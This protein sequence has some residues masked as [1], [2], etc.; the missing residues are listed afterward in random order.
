MSTE[1]IKVLLV[2]AHEKPVTIEIP[3]NLKGFQQ[4]VGGYIE[5]YD[6]EDGTSL[7]CDDEANLKYKDGNRYFDDGG[8]IAGD[9]IVVG[10]TED[11]NCRSL[12]D[13]EVSK[14]MD[15]YADAPDISPAE[16]AAD[17]GFTSFTF[18]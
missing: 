12:T 10:T 16:T 7:I 2:Q 9:F 18:S 4:A 6:N 1:T 11:G 5:F 13:A 8:I 15:K 3:N 17:A 14:Y